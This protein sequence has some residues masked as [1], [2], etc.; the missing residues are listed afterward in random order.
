MGFGYLKPNMLHGKNEANHKASNSS[1][2]SDEAK[3]SVKVKTKR[4]S[5]ECSDVLNTRFDHTAVQTYPRKPLRETVT[6][7]NIKHFILVKSKYEI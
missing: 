6:V 5:A 3:K 2:S 7:D 4:S 1:N